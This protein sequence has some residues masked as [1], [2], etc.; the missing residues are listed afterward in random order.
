MKWIA[1]S[2]LVGIFVCSAARAGAAAETIHLGTAQAV[3]WTVI[4]ADVGVE[5]NSFVRYGLEVEVTDMGGDAEL[6]QALEMSTLRSKSTDDLPF[7]SKFV[8]VNP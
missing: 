1:G 3:P 6:R 7:A 2:V 5:Q 4:P 8:P